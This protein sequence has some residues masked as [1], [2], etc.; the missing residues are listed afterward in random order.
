[1]DE[2]YLQLHARN[3]MSVEGRSIGTIVNLSR[4]RGK[5]LIFVVQEARQ[6]DV[7]VI[8]QADVIAVKELSQIS[9]EFERREL[10]SLTDKARAE[11]SLI[12]GD[13]R[14]WTWVYSEKADFTGMAEN[15][16]ASFWRLA[17]SQAFARGGA[18]TP[19]TAPN[20]NRDS[21][22]RKGTSA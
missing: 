14:R 12:N 10:R 7:N 1:M 9:R 18:T 21:M 5:S 16:L 13:R 20:I 17:L 22:P 19:N 4:Q 6:L 3:S 8:S 15:Q 2:A 11:F